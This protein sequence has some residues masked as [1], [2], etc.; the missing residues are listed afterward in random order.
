MRSS[1]IN[2]QGWKEKRVLGGA[3]GEARNRQAKKGTDFYR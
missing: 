2:L 3:G 1:V